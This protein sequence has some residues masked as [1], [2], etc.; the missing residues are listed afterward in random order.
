M[1]MTNFIRYVALAAFVSYAVAGQADRL[2]K[3]ELILRQSCQYNL[4]GLATL[5]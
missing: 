5:S 2:E 1:T 4:Q 3:R